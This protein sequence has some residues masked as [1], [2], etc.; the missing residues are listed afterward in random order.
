MQ[1]SKS[2]TK[3]GKKEEEKQEKRGAGKKRFFA[4]E[5]KANVTLNLQTN[6]L[7]DLHCF[8]GLQRT[9]ITWLPFC[10][11]TKHFAFLALQ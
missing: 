11:K 10:I 9:L 3:R 8:S 7:A 5:M 1:P 4:L 6:F 2:L